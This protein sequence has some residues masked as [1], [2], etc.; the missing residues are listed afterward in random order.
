MVNREVSALTIEHSARDR[1]DSPSLDECGQFWSFVGSFILSRG[2]IEQG[3]VFFGVVGL[4]STLSGSKSMLFELPIIHDRTNMPQNDP[5]FGSCLFTNVTGF[6]QLRTSEPIIQK[7][8]KNR[9][10]CDMIKV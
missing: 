4:F 3:G 2:V 9:V 7:R 1:A 10:V 8:T 6:V 5:R